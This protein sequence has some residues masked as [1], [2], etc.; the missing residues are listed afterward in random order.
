MLSAE[1][2]KSNWDLHLKIVDT[3]IT[4]RKEKIQSMLTKLEPILVTSPA[5]TKSH[6]HGAYLGGYIQHVNNVVKYALKQAE[7]FKTLGGKI[8]FEIEELV[9]SALFH[10]LGKIGDGEKENY[11]PQED[12]WRKEKLQEVFTINK[13][14]DFMLIPD[15]SIFI[16]QKFGIQMSI[17]EFLAIKLHDGLFEETNKPYYISYNPDS[18][19]KSNIVPIL[20]VADYLSSKIEK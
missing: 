10:D 13:D 6:Y 9:F 4:S 17:N 8:D 11:Q 7:L 14:L 12:K 5:S 15:R 1:K 19:F 16:L 3:Y 18:T 2:I 20:H